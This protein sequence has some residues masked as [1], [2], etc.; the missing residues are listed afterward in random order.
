MINS[1]RAKLAKKKELATEI[2]Q[3]RYELQQ[4][5]QIS[6]LAGQ[7]ASFVVDKKIRRS[8]SISSA[9]S[10]NGAIETIVDVKPDGPG[11]RFFAGAEEGDVAEFLAPL[12][13]FVYEDKS[14]HIPNETGKTGD[15][16][17]I[18][19]ATGTGITPF[20]SMFAEQLRD[21]ENRRPFKLYWGLRYDRDIYLTSNL[22]ELADKFTN[23]NYQLTLSKPTR[24]WQGR[25]GYITSHII[26]DWH[27]IEKI[28]SA[29]FYLCGGGTMIDNAVE[30]LTIKGISD[31]QIHYEKFY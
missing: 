22:Q 3:L 26:E 11:S 31:E 25:R 23:F 1:F 13:R 27:Q 6:F 19:L 24:K 20:L 21:K 10:D 14:D 17:A 12:G 18:F 29:D 2:F 8:Y 16:P 7:F 30:E 4:P 28:D 5:Q 9:P 15:P